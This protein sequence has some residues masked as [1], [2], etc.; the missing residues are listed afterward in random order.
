MA[1]SFYLRN[2]LLNPNTNTNAK[3]FS[4]FPYDIIIS[5]SIICTYSCRLIFIPRRL[6]PSTVTLFVLCSTR[7]IISNLWD[8]DLLATNTLDHISVQMIY[9]DHST[10]S[11]KKPSGWR[12]TCSH[13]KHCQEYHILPWY[14]LLFGHVN[15]INYLWI[16][17]HCIVP[18][19]NLHPCS[20]ISIWTRYDHQGSPWS[21]VVQYRDHSSEIILNPDA[22][23]NSYGH[24]FTLLTSLHTCT[25]RIYHA[26]PLHAKS[27]CARRTASWPN[28][29]LI[30][31]I[32][33]FCITI[34]STMYMLTWYQ[35]NHITK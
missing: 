4:K 11:P 3:L 28:L 27:S 30:T 20:E 14:H 17:I 7:V 16:R 1:S 33:W 34:I 22:R 21:K 10:K 29:P 9:H 31:W 24:L 19:D 8:I 13:N 18:R 2:E 23:P 35:I 26:S 12:L 6:P 5:I 15:T 32:F 25:P